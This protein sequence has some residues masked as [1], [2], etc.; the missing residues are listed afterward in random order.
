MPQ[1]EKS[2]I[3]NERPVICLITPEVLALQIKMFVS[4]KIL[5]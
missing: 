5:T 3:L 4:N 2:T 1:I